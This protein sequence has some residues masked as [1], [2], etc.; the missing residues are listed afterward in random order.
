MYIYKK[1]YGYTYIYI[2]IYMYLF[3]FMCVFVILDVATIVFLDFSISHSSIGPHP[4]K[5]ISVMSVVLFLP[6]VSFPFC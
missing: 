6:L 3:M 1:I 5:L 4:F 2:Y